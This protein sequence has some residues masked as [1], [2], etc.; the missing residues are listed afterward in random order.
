VEYCFSCHDHIDKLTHC[1]LLI[2]V[3]AQGASRPSSGFTV[4]EEES[5]CEEPD[6]ESHPKSM[7]I[8]G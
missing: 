8:D 2:Y 1:F 5:K 6:V 3:D 4:S 7:K